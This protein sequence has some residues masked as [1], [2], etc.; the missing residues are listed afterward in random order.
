[1]VSQDRPVRLLEDDL[2][3]LDYVDYSHVGPDI[4]HDIRLVKYIVIIKTDRL[5]PIGKSRLQ[6]IGKSRLTAAGYR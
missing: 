1:M 4:N 6:P 5:Q 3:L 2:A